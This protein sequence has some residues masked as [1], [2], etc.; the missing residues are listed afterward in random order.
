M[1]ARHVPDGEDVAIT[2]HG[3]QVT[4]TPRK[5]DVL[6][7]GN[8]K[9]DEHWYQ[10]YAVDAEH[11]TSA[12]FDLSLPVFDA[13]LQRNDSHAL[14]LYRFDEGQGLTIYD[15]SAIG[16]PANITIFKSANAHWLASHGLSLHGT[17]PAM[18]A[19][20]VRKLMALARGDAFT[21]ELWVSTDTIAPPLDVHGCMLSWEVGREQQNFSVGQSWY[22][23]FFDANGRNFNHGMGE[24]SGGNASECARPWLQHLVFTYQNKHLRIY[25][26]GVLQSDG[27]LQGMAPAK[28]Y[29]NAVLLLGNYADGSAAYLGTYYLAAIHDRGMSEAEVQH[30]YQAGPTAR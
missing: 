12:P 30:N 19:K 8:S 6:T 29:A 22:D 18:T 9:T 17:T 20:A 26:N 1:V 2:V 21:I 13:R 15:H 28:W 25:A 3:L 27:Q 24:N 23:L 7:A 16:S 11:H 10:I 14:V 5:A 4:F